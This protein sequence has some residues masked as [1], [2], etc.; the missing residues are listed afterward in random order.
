MTTRQLQWI[1][2]CLTVG[3][4]SHA[5]ARAETDCRWLERGSTR[6]LRADCTTDATLLIPDG[7][8]LDGRG[9]R[10][11]ARDPPEGAFEGAVVRNAGASAHV[12]N[13]EIDAGDL[14]AVCHPAE[15]VDTRVR[16]ILLQDA[17]G[18]VTDSHVLAINQGASGCQEGSA[19]EVRA[20]R[21]VEVEIRGNRIENFQKTGI[22]VIGPIDAGIYLNRIEGQGPIA[23]LAQNGI[24]LSEGATGSIKL[25]HVRDLRYTPGTATSAGI[26]LLDA[27]DGVDVALNRVADTDVGIF[28]ART[29]NAE[30]HGNSIDRSTYDGISIDGRTGPAQENH[31]HANYIA[32]SG[33]VGIDLFGAGARNNVIKLNLI[34]AS[35]VADVEEQLEAG[36]NVVLLNGALGAKQ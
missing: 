2:L 17:D 31:V 18:S 20:N 3:S 15:P 16:A 33:S 12:R 5:T 6:Y 11:T 7:F 9:H 27:G 14:A 25:N 36:E 8:T 30:L 28:L 34:V 22:V 19:I 10:I 26:L 21:E 35:G 23:S 4:L 1:A 29:S 32:N 24:Q 13:L